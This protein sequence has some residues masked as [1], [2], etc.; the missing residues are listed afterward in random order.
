M[1]VANHQKPHPAGIYERGKRSGQNKGIFSRSRNRA[2]TFHRRLRDA[3]VASRMVARFNCA[4]YGDLEICVLGCDG[5][6]RAFVF[7]CPQRWGRMGRCVRREA[8]RH[9]PTHLAKVDRA[10]LGT[11]LRRYHRRSS[12]GCTERYGV[13]SRV[14]V[15][16]IMCT[17][18]AYLPFRHDR[19]LKEAPDRVARTP[20]RIQAGRLRGSCSACIRLLAIHTHR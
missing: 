15:S 16:L 17:G 18:G 12:S 8:P 3:V 4:I 11:P 6:V 5:I 13:I 7:P 9:S 1:C 2:E 20:D 10:P 14:S 19:H